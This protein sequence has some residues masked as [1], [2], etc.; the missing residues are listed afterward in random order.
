M[1]MV[2]VEGFFGGIGGG[3]VDGEIRDAPSESFQDLH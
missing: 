3:G 2:V 1:G